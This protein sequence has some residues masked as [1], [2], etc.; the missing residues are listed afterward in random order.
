[1]QEQRLNGSTQFGRTGQAFNAPGPGTNSLLFGPTQSE[2]NVWTATVSSFRAGR[3]CLAY[4][5]DPPGHV[6][7]GDRLF[8]AY[9][10][11]FYPAPNQS[12][13]VGKFVYRMV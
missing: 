9:L 2:G 5:G 3:G 4:S 11:P 8:D 1:M 10:E 12:I 13:S 7:G 6:S